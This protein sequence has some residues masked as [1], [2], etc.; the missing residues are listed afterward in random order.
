MTSPLSPAPAG[1]RPAPARP[2][3]VVTADGARFTVLTDRLI[4]MEHSR[5]GDFVDAATQL[6]VS[7]DLGPVPNF[8]VRRG[9]DRLK[10]LTAHLYLTYQPSRGFSRSGL[11]VSLRTAVISPHGGA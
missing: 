8:E 10:I 2:D 4:R 5:T 9:K 3:A 7:R 1:L 6:V 11:T